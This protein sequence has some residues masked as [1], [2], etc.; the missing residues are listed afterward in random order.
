MLFRAYKIYPKAWSI[1][2]LLVLGVLVLQ[3]PAQAQSARDLNNRLDR[4][5]NEIKTLS[6]AIFKGEEPPPGAFG[7]TNSAGAANAEIRLQQMEGELQ[8]LRGMIEQQGH[9][10]RQ[11]QSELE[12]VTSDMEL[13]IGDLE[14]GAG[15]AVSGSTSES[16]VYNKRPSSQ[17]D[18]PPQPSNAK[19]SG[20]SWS[21]ENGSK[22]NSGQLGSY[23][24][25]SDSGT[26]SGNAD[27]AAELYESAF[28]Q[29]KSNNYDGAETEFQEFL[30]QYPDHVLVGNAKYWLGETYYV[31][32]KHEQAAR[33][34]AEG[35]QQFPKGNKAADNLL[36]L[37]MSL[38]AMGKKDDACVALGQ[39]SKEGFVNAGPVLRRADQEKTR[40]G[41]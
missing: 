18:M 39:I 1:L 41:C 14:K 24:Q 36:K 37:G 11:L 9:E 3:A 7:N 10:V 28:A 12:R 21:S 32:G 23:K 16:S 19:G 27:S 33:M 4:V 40:L 34:F 8:N 15:G 26:I 20:Y 13:R 25:S 6:R 38:A 30:S 2:G 5:E 35:Y 22:N 17:E 29:L 31:R